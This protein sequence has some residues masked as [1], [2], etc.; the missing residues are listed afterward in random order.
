MQFTLSRKQI[1]AFLLF[2]A[3][4]KDVRYYLR[5]LHIRQDA[6][7]TILEATNGHIMGR[8]RIDA[9]PKPMRNVIMGSEHLAS[10]AKC[11]K[12]DLDQLVEFY[13]TAD[14]TIT[15][16]CA[17]MTS[18]FKALDGTFPDTDRIT[19]KV[20]LGEP[21]PATYNPEYIVAFHDAAKLLVSEKAYPVLLQ[22][23]NQVAIVG[24][25]DPEFLG[26][27]M[28]LREECTPTLPEW[29]YQP[30]TKPEP[31]TATA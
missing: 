6:R 20:P 7:G 26:L 28:P 23:G 30:A 22:R 8:L 5:G 29:A 25:G 1:K 9:S 19:P 18:S 11:G 3:G 13:V 15:A 4:V 21:E 14:G 12:R 27:L 31:E 2:T 24:I 16:S 17:G 10:W